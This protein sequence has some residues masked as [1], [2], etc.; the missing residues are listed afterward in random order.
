M[1]ASQWDPGH[2]SLLYLRHSFDS[3]HVQSMRPLLPGD[4]LTSGCRGCGCSPTEE[5]D[6]NER[7][8]ASVGSTLSHGVREPRPCRV[9]LMFHAL[10][11][12]N[13]L[14]TCHSPTGSQLKCYDRNRCFWVDS[15]SP[16]LPQKDLQVDKGVKFTGVSA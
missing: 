2:P 1:A 12:T 3:I 7:W 13:L 9:V 15:L 11:G 16:R 14:V 10:S 6:P 4:N 8:G 5:S